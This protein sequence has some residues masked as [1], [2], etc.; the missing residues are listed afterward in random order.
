MVA[1][2]PI[3]KL[4]AIKQP[5]PQN[6]ANQLT[7][8][9]SKTPTANYL[10]VQD[11]GGIYTTSTKIDKTPQDRNNL[12][13]IMTSSKSK[14]MNN[15]GPQGEPQ[16]QLMQTK[17]KKHFDFENSILEA[18]PAMELAHVSSLDKQLEPNAP[19]KES[20]H[21]EEQAQQAKNEPSSPDI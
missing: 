12:G 10:R 9:V 13:S 8:P 16:Q 4:E 14:S 5:Q 21:E 15:L 1:D 20:K 2:H 18:P 7:L 11:D 3:F 17:S 19:A 6:K